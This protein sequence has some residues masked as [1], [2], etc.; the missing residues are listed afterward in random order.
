MPDGLHRASAW[1]QLVGHFLQRQRQNKPSSSVFGKCER[2][3]ELTKWYMLMRVQ[4][5][6][7]R[8]RNEMKQL[9]W[10]T[11]SQKS[12][13][14]ILKCCDMLIMFDQSFLNTGLR[15]RVTLDVHGLASIFEDET[16]DRSKK[17]QELA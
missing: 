6:L 15:F 13:K 12:F 11:P 3:Y 2:T 4:H 10:L 9:A 7:V 14:I 8:A 1:S 16:F 5:V 17:M